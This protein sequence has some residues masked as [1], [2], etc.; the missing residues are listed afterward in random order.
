LIALRTGKAADHRAIFTET[1]R[2]L[3]KHWRQ[4]EVIS[5]ALLASDNAELRGPNPQRL[6]AINNALLTDPWG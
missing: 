3:I 2:L 4:I 5:E 1:R 6:L